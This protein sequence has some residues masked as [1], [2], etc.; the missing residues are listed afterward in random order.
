M[1]T[2][3]PFHLVTVSPW[4]FYGSCATCGFV[5]GIGGMVNGLLGSP[6]L[7][8]LS[9][10]GISYTMLVWWRDIVREATFEG[11]HTN[12]VQQGLRIYL[13]PEHWLP[14]LPRNDWYDLSV[15]MFIPF[16]V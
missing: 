1:L 12:Q 3:H 14:W 15:C 8:F 9:L 5:L 13:L 4:P 7:I 16:I 11:N 2:R 6:I 10:T